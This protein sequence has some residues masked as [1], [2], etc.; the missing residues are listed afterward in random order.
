LKKIKLNNGLY[1]TVDVEDYEFLLDFS[2][3]VGTPWKVL[4]SHFSNKAVVTANN[5][6]MHRILIKAKAGTCV[7]HINGDGLDNRKIN[8][9]WSCNRS[10]SKAT[11]KGIMRN[12]RSG[13]RGVSNNGPSYKKKWRAE[14]SYEGVRYRLGYFYKK[15]EAARA[16]DAKAYELMGEAAYL[17]FPHKIDKNT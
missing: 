10:Y 13:F 7:T 14:L 11:Q 9:K 3:I 5:N 12:N 4:T 15:E 2:E 6:L 1:A 8:L 16:Y 17:N